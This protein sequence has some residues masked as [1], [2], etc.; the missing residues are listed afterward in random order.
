MRAKVV[1]DCV[2]EEELELKKTAI[3]IFQGLLEGQAK[4]AAVY[5]R[6]LSVIHLGNEKQSL[7]TFNDISFK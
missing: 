6:V 7:I 5:E 4:K 1:A 2:Y 3:D